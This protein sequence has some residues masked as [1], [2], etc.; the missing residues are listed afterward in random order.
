MAVTEMMKVASAR[1]EAAAVKLRSVRDAPFTPTGLQEW[2]NALTD[3][4]LALGEVQELSQGA[5]HVSP[6]RKAS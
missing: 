5:I 4:A 6:R 3:Y 1:M 2:L